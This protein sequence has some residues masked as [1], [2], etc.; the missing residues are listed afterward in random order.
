M[1]QETLRTYIRKTIKELLDED[2]LNETSFSGGA[3]AYNTPFAFSRKD[4]SGKKKK[5]E[6][7]TNSTGYSIVEG[8]YHEYRNDDTLTPR[9]KIGRSMREIRDHLSEIDKLT[10]MNVRLKNE[11]DVDSRSYWKN[12]H[13]AMRKV[14]ERLVKLANRVGQLY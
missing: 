5:K 2:G 6:V 1:S 12:T 9:Q 13:K 8:K 3:G 7:A 4:K 11:M 14:S 10:K